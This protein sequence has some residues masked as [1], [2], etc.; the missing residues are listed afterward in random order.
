MMDSCDD[1]RH[2]SLAVPRLALHDSMILNSILSLASRYDALRQNQSPC[3]EAI[4]YNNRCIESLIRSL[5]KPPETYG[6]EL[7][8]AVVMARSYEECDFEL[9]LSHFHLSGTRNLLT[10]DNVTR[11]ASKGGLAEASC[12]VHLRQSIYAYIVR[13]RPV[14]SHLDAFARLTAFSRKDD[15]AY[16]NQM[17]Y[18]F[19]RVLSLFFPT[20]QPSGFK[21][22]GS[23]D[24]WT[25]LRQEIDGWHASKP[26]SFKPIFYGPET[27]QGFPTLMMLGAAPGKG[28]FAC[29]TACELTREDSNGPSIL[30][31]SYDR[32]HH[33]PDC[34]FPYFRLRGSQGPKGSRGKIIL[35]MRTAGY[36]DRMVELHRL[37]DVDADGIMPFQ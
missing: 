7:L 9:D 16:A 35:F 27:I 26:Q 11:L 1:L 30:Q 10:H 25:S 29:I 3:V 19:A 6:S 2:Y 31:R 14:D 22:G 23:D 28:S 4:R 24:S 32:D 18:H 17:V 36:A 15:S 13:Q 33:E 37:N 20:T 8:V 12:W 5:S 34:V 21:G